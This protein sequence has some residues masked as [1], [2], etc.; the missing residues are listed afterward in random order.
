MSWLGD[1]F[2]DKDV[3]SGLFQGGAALATG[4]LN[5][6]VQKENNQFEREIAQQK[7]EQDREL[8]MAQIAASS[9]NSAAGNATAKEIAKRQI[10]AKLAAQ[11]GDLVSRSSLAGADRLKNKDVEIPQSISQMF[12]R[13][14]GSL[15]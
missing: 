9:A 12:A 10:A 5:N 13:V 8:T 15:G 14:Q 7:L 11:Y 3:L 4:L 2:S 1:I 6:D